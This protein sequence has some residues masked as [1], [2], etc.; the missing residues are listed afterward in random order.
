MTKDELRARIIATANPKPILVDIPEWA[1][2]YVKP[3]LVGEI[4]SEK[5]D[6]DPTFAT[7]RGVAGV[8]CDENGTLLFDAKNPDDLALINGLQASSLTK[9]N[10]AMGA[11][12]QKGT[13]AEAIDLGNVSPPATDS[14]ST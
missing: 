10:Q 12:N 9:I 14:S 2:V 5:Q 13:S 4:E 7:A 8:L 11:F 3:M 6:L 1:G